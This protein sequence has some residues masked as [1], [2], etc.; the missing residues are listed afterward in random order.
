L[1]S[2]KIFVHS[3]LSSVNDILDFSKKKRNEIREK[4]TFRENSRG[5]KTMQKYER[6]Q[7]LNFQ[8]SISND[9]PAVI[10]EMKLD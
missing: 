2:Y 1:P 4:I 7:G 5:L 10:K 3:L 6:R 8:F 9:M